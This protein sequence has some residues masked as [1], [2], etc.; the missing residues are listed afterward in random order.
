MSPFAALL[1]SHRERKRWSQECLAFEC[2][3]DHSLASR[4]ERDQRRPTRDSLAKLCAGLGLTPA[5]ADELYLAAGF[6]PPDTDTN[7]LV[8]VLALLRDGRTA[9]RAVSL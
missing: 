3:I 2:A 4:L 6:V 1:R 8:R 7:L 9:E 5:Q